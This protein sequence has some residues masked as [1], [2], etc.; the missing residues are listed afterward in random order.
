MLQLAVIF[1][2]RAKPHFFCTSYCTV[3]LAGD[4]LTS[5]ATR[6]AAY[7]DTSLLCTYIK[8]LFGIYSLLYPE[9]LEFLRKVSR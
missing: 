4:I 5:H 6:Q 8:V 3:F 7:E 9:D 2:R 1:Y